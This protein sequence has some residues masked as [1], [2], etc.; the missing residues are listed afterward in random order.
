MNCT[1]GLMDPLPV[2]PG[3][4]RIRNKVERYE[5]MAER[6]LQYWEAQRDTVNEGVIEG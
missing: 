4:K 3:K 5:K 6:A 2:E 1:Y